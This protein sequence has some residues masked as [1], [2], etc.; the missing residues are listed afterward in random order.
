MSKPLINTALAFQIVGIVWDFFYHV[1]NGGL[2][3][4]FAAAHWP[5]FLGFVLLIVAVL[6]SRQGKKK[7]EPN[8]QSP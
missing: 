5:I 4:F 2:Q 7:E 3:D 8:N 6:Q 1:N